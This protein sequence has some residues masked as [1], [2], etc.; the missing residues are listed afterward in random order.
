MNELRWILIGFGIV[1][2]A[3][4]YLWGRRGNRAVASDD[5]MVRMR[6]EPTVHTGYSRYRKRMLQAG[7]KLYEIDPLPSERL[8]LAEMRGSPVLRIH[9]KAAVVDRRVVYLGSMNLD[10]RS[11]ALNTEIGV[12][13]E[14]EA[15]AA[16][17]LQLVEALM[18]RQAWQV[19]LD[20]DG[21]LKWSSGEPDTLESVPLASRGGALSIEPETNGPLVITGSLELCCGTGRTI[22]RVTSTRLCRCGGSSNKPYCDNSHRTNGFRS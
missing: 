6:P 3:A 2:L 13:I 7:A 5:A 17:V 21:E 19:W 9:T 16:D 11:V 15:L 1:L 10:P 14:S 22:N 18:A 12:I 4:I 20:A 8:V